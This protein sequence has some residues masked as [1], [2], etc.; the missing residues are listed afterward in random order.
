MKYNP[1]DLISFYRKPLKMMAL[2]IIMSILGLSL[3]MLSIG[4]T[5]GRKMERKNHIAKEAVQFPQKRGLF[6]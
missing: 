2:S 1:N 4:L 3:S 5:I 6:Y